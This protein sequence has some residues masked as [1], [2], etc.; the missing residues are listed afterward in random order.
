MVSKD[1]I[2]SAA[3]AVLLSPTN[4]SDSTKLA[5]YEATAVV[6]LSCLHP[7]NRAQNQK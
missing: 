1:I 5:S 7:P 2:Q 4:S 3:E 6:K